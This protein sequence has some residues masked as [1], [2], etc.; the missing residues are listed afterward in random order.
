[1][2][3]HRGTVAFKGAINGLQEAVA[4]AVSLK[5]WLTGSFEPRRLGGL[6]RYLADQEQRQQHQSVLMNQ[7]LSDLRS[8]VAN[9]GQMVAVAGRVAEKARNGHEDAG[10]VQ[11]L[12]N[13]FGISGISA[14]T[15]SLPISGPGRV[16][17]ELSGDVV[18]VAITALE[19]S[20]GIL[21]LH[22][23]YALFNRALGTDLVTPD[24]LMR[25]VNFAV[26]H[27]QLRI[28][29]F[30]RVKAVQLASL[31]EKELC[32]AVSREVAEWNGVTSVRYAAFRGVSPSMAELILRDAEQSALLCRDSGHQGTIFHAVPKAWTQYPTT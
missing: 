8:L 13:D 6:S 30:G 32:A 31:S 15:T 26:H 29:C 5:L 25:A 12:L 7:G 10:E 21:L 22:D 17:A 19:K 3:T 11:K 18:R 4:E 20:G 14:S 9:A 2:H 1:M 23:L 24:D 27:G 28:R 16:E